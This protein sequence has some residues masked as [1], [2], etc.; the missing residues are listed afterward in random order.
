[1]VKVSNRLGA[2]HIVR[3][4]REK[5][6]Q[7]FYAGGCVRDMLLGRRPKDYDVVTDALP[8]QIIK[9]FRRTLEIGAQ[10]GVIMVL[11]DGKQVEVATFRTEH[12]YAD[13]R[14]PDQVEFATAKEDAYRRD[15][16]INGMF[17]DPVSRQIHDFV[18]GQQDI[19]RRILRT[20][21]P[22]RERFGEDY[23]RMLRA[24]RFAVRFDF[25]MEPTTW[26]AICELSGRITR[27]SAER[28]ANELEGILTHPNRKH[29]GQC[30][31][32]SG[33]LA[34]I[35][36]GLDSGQVDDGLSVMGFLPKNADWPLALAALF[37][38]LDVQ[39]ALE[40]V[41][42]LKPS[43]SLVK[44]VAFLLKH[45]GHLA[46]G[47]IPLAQ[48]KM[49]AAEPYFWDLFDLQKAIQKAQK[50]PRAGLARI[51]RRLKDLKGKDITPRPLL[52]GHALMAL[53]ALP[54][55]MVGRLSREMYIAQ[56]SE[57]ISTEE[58]AQ[59]WVRK[60]LDKNLS[61]YK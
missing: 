12:G 18:G 1:M 25:A 4:L 51:K 10:F 14:H 31:H 29:G 39:Q 47:D 34:H 30:L 8:E 21:G 55:P 26:D 27:I 41:E 49:L 53:G 33:L 23:L 61:T 56:L 15:F 3:R 57:Q 9:L 50:G 59:K 43:R 17:F 46:D 20:I 36:P 44:Q 37:A 28:V 58:Q 52:D 7:A 60:W 24:I 32:N 5:G 2:L 22:A 16:T 40:M 45:R 54:G 42:R 38:G 19:Q 35:F 13:G 48:L 6:F 11:M